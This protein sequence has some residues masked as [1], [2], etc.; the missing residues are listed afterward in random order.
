M[1]RQII[2]NQSIGTGK[3]QAYLYAYAPALRRP[4][5]ARSCPLTA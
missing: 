4:G 1:K 3:D 2:M 5:G